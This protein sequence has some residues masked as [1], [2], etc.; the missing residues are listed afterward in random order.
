MVYKWDD[1]EKL[2]DPHYGHTC[3][4]NNCRETNDDVYCSCWRK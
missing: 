3:F 4:H 2:T 1:V